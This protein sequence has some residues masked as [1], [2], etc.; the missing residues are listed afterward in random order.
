MGR[1][2]FVFDHSV[3]NGCYNCQIA[4]KDEHCNNDWPPYSAP[5]PMTGQYWCK[6]NETTHGQ[7]PKV[8][9]EYR[10]VFG[11]QTEAIRKYAPEV[12]MDR[13]DGLVVI[14]PEKAKGRKDL[15]EKFE[16]VYWNEE[17]NIP[18]G[19]NGCAHLVDAGELPHCVDACTLGALRFGDEEEFAEQ[20]ANAEQIDP[21]SS[22]YYINMPHLF[23]AGE[24][25]DP[26]DNEVIIG[27]KVVL[28]C[29]DKKWE[30]TTDEFGDFWF[31]RIDAGE[32][33][34][35]IEAEGFK[36]QEKDFVLE[37]SLNLGDFALEK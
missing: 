20:I 9:L 18:Q 17:L 16:G 12:L 3:C 28:T 4:C 24:V 21:E 27:A 25:W 30:T 32:Y 13:E 6:L 35:S 5:E 1:K 14:E 10:P 31:R 8:R 11:A 23:A 37:K 36:G 29:G 22:V 19:C 2:V 7:A 15:A 33:H 26:V 34:L